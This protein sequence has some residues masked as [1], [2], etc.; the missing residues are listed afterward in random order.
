MRNRVQISMRSDGVIQKGGQKRG[1]YA[2]CA[3]DLTYGAALLVLICAG[4]QAATITGTIQ[5]QQCKPEA[6]AIVS[7]VVKAGP[8]VAVAAA[9][10]TAPVAPPPPSQP[11]QTGPPSFMPV[12]AKAASGADGSFEIDNVPAGAVYLCATKADSDVL[13]PCWWSATPPTVTAPASGV[14]LVVAH[15]VTIALRVH[16]AQGLIAARPSVD[17]IL[18]G[19][20]QGNSPFIPARVMERDGAGKTLGLTVPPAAVLNL[21][22]RS[23]NF[24]MN[25]DKGLALPVGVGIPLTAPAV[26]SAIGPTGLPVALMTVHVTGR[27]A[28]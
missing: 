21:L 10:V 20:T 15:G 8:A 17:D 18:I 28:R 12:M 3:S 5:D 25:D 24:S 11:I 14:S 2:A 19:T 16:D 23:K 27:V 4:A 9:T 26:S 7:A 1:S 22:V 13:N 6:G